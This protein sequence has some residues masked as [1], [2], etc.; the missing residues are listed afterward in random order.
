MT[1]NTADVEAR[2]R[3]SIERRIKAL[4]PGEEQRILGLSVRRTTR[5]HGDE[6]V[7]DV[8]GENGIRLDTA[9]STQ[10]IYHYHETRY[11]REAVH[12]YAPDPGP[13]AN[14]EERVYDY[15]SGRWMSTKGAY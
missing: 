6:P 8:G 3:A 2:L 14:L 15:P 1:D 13:P 7:F 9:D 10:A 11:A 12:P 4:R 5:D